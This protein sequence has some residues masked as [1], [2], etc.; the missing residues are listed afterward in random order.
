MALT[1]KS[2]IIPLGLLGIMFTLMLASSWSDSAIMDELA[3][4]PAGY[5]YVFLRDYRLNP[6]HPPLLKML[7]ALP[8][9]FTDVQFPTDAR[10]WTD[11]VN[12]QWEQGRLFLYGTGNDAER[13][14]GLMRLPEMLL[15]ILFGAMLWAWTRRHLDIRTANLALF[16]YTLSPTF[17]AHSR[18]VTT[19]LAAAFGFFIGIVAFLRFL[20]S[21]TAKNILIAG[22]AL[23]VAELLKFS[24][25]LLVPIYGILLVGWL[26]SRME[27]AWPER[28]WLCL[29]LAG[30]TILIGLF[31]LVAVW[32]VYAYAVWNYPPERQYRDTESILSSFGSR[33]AAELDLWLTRHRLTRPLGQYLLGLLMVIQRAEGGN[34]QYFLGEVSALGDIRYFP[35]LYL[36]KEPLALHL[37]TLIALWFACRRVAGAP[38]KSLAAVLAWIREHF[39]QFA[40]FSF[41][42]VYWAT[43]LSST[44]NIGVRH[45][46]PTFPFIYMLVAGE[47]TAWLR[48]WP[49]SE[50]HTWGRWL[51]HVYQKYVASLPR[52]LIVSALLVW[53]AVSVLST[54]PHYLSYYNILA[55][56]AARAVSAATADGGLPLT[57]QAGG[58]DVGYLIGVDSNYD[59]GQDLKRLVLF[60]EENDIG[61]LRLDYFGGG[62]PGYYFG[63]GY[64]PWWS[65]RGYPSTSS[66]QVPSGGGWFAI[67]A[68]FQ[69]SA[70]GTPVKNFQRKPEDSYEW[71]KPFRPVARAGKSIFIYH[72]PEKP[73]PGINAL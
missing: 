21:P 27:L 37:L 13:I 63:D 30:K 32:L 40:A 46:L 8:L 45:V 31:A 69:M 28:L 57:G 43:T 34:T 42:A 29:R 7:A 35:M 16:F 50:T 3:H 6:E 1:R 58:T 48:S 22:L 23:G 5:S 10:S 53:M 71:L 62:D 41:I 39:P 60:T 2:S 11:D 73:P 44:L 14:L 64:E 49:R 65:A 67:S 38:Q 12:G 52:Y 47:I 24:L 20:K 54:F 56:L 51:F 55:P 66:G 15:A 72:L 36:L 70:Y 18:F 25:I 68:S 9:A 61:R 26:I 19:D 59:W 33:P 4:V 17:I